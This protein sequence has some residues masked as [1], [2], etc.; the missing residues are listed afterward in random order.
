MNQSKISVP[1]IN[2]N[3]IHIAT[4]PFRLVCLD[5]LHGWFLYSENFHSSQYTPPP[6]HSA[7][8]RGRSRRIHDPINN[9]RHPGDGDRCRNWLGQE[10]TYSR[11]KKFSFA[12]EFNCKV[13]QM[14]DP[15][16]IPESVFSFFHIRSKVYL[17]SE[18]K[19]YEKYRTI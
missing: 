12:R 14:N 16:R 4:D 11:G 19:E 2:Q 10:R 9:P 1:G 6:C 5:S 17:L 13:Q 8:S 18:L 3:S 15:R 7:R